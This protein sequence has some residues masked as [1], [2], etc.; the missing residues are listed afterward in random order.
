M[1]C[2]IKFVFTFHYVSIKTTTPEYFDKHFALFTFHY[3]SIKTPAC[4]LS[5]FYMPSFTFHYV[6]IKTEVI[7]PVCLNEKTLHSTMSLLKPHM[8]IL[9]DFSSLFNTLL[10]TLKNPSNLPNIC[11]AL[12]MQY[13]CPKQ[14]NTN[15]VDLPVKMHFTTS[16][17]ITCPL[18]FL[19]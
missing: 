1:M 6:S 17:V 4:L 3:V 14:I 19:L 7:M 12:N 11:P 15:L 10:S 16:T 5:W 18:S 8:H 2:E 13:F 9:V